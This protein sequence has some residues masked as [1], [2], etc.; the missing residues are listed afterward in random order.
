MNQLT[1][2]SK[3]AKVIRTREGLEAFRTDVMKSNGKHLK[4]KAYTE[5]YKLSSSFVSYLEGLG[6]VQ[7]LDP[8]G[9]KHDGKSLKWTY[10]KTDNGVVDSTLVDALINAERQYQKDWRASKRGPEELQ[11]VVINK[12]PVATSI[13][14]WL[15]KEL[16]KDDKLEGDYLKVECKQK[17]QQIIT[18]L[19][20]MKEL[21]A[22]SELIKL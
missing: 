9:N 19:N 4:T 13:I 2:K 17:Y 5:T 8:N 1:E 14:D 15:T 6:V 12:K 7:D 16:E 21:K 11:P 22:L 18:T 10:S 20:S 3:V